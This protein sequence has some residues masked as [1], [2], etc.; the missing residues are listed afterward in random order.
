VDD[1][2]YEYNALNEGE[3]MTRLLNNADFNKI[4]VDGF[5][6]D[7]LVQLG[8]NFASQSNMRSEYAEQIIARKHFRDYINTLITTGLQAKDTIENNQYQEGE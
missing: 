1:M 4:F 8:Y 3:A 5:L 7:D 2:T 6:K